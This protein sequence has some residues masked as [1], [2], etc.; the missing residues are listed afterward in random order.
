MLPRTMLSRIGSCLLTATV[1]AVMGPACTGPVEAPEEAEEVGDAPQEIIGGVDA[2]SPR[3]NAVGSLVITQ[4]ETDPDT[5]EVVT[6]HFP[7][8][9]GA[10]IGG[11]TVLTAKHCVDLIAYVSA[12]FPVKVQF[13]VGPDGF[14]PARTI[15]VVGLARA[16]GDEGGFVGMG[17]DVGI[18][19]LDEEVND[20]AP[21]AL[22]MVH[23]DDIGSRFSAIGYGIQDN[24]GRSGTRKA[25]S[26][27]LRAREGKLF[28]LIFGSFEAFKDYAEENWG[29]DPSSGKLSCTKRN[30][31]VRPPEQWLD[32]PSGVEGEEAAPSDEV[33]QYAYDNTLLL[34]DHEA[35]LGHAPGDAQPCFGDSGS[36][37]VKNVNGELRVYGVVSG[38]LG[39]KQLVCDFGAVYATLG[40]DT[41]AFLDQARGWTDP[42]T[43]SVTGVCDGDVAERCTGIAEGQRRVTRTDC[44]LLG[45]TCGQDGHGNAVCVDLPDA[46]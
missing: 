9:S 12:N 4:E 26:V 15:E 43:I 2:E 8:C 19:Y 38:G 23:D 45:Q 30:C 34:E 44:S 36:P 22:A 21:L 35:W 28:E 24:A 27:R 33:L 37:L 39:S 32:D 14:N 31:F 20:I 17:S 1:F 25:G 13:G 18:A 29:F 3:L 42:C 6:S 10:L 40:P 16:P 11:S 46:Q 7:F 41:Y 5:G